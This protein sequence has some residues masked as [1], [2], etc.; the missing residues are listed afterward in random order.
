MMF[1]LLFSYQQAIDLQTEYYRLEESKN[2]DELIEF[3]ETYNKEWR[4]M[5]DSSNERYFPQISEEF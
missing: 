1:F 5:I 4:E 3:Y 2:T